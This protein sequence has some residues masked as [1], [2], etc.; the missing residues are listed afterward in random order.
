[1]NADADV[2]TSKRSNFFKRVS[3]LL[4]LLYLKLPL[5]DHIYL[6]FLTNFELS[7]KGKKI[8]FNLVTISERLNPEFYSFKL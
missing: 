8:S 2:W 3:K 6:T 5:F 1:M 4:S 7:G